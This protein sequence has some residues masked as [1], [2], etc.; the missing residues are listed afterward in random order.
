MSKIYQKNTSGTKKRVKS[1]L[2]GFTLIELLVVVLIIGILAAIA[3]PQYEKAVL[4]SRYA[5][6]EISFRALYDALERYQLANGSFPSDLSSLD[7]TLPGT[8]ISPENRIIQNEDYQCSYSYQI[9]GAANALHCTLT[10]GEQVGLRAINND[11]YRNKRFCTALASSEK[12][13]EFCKSMGGK[14]PF[15]SGAGLLHYELP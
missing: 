12:G 4:R 8:L 11:T 13:Q 1:Y 15:D 3:L 2:G 5:Q 14:A 9:A 7:I 6:L 10:K